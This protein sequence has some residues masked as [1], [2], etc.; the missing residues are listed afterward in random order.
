MTNAVQEDTAEQQKANVALVEKMYECFNRA[1]LDT[2][3]SE[4]FAADLVWILP[5]RNPVGGVKNGPDEVL[6]FFGALNSANIQVDLDRID[7]WGPDTVVE[8]H[9]GHGT[10]NGASLDALN[11]THYKIA[12]GR[13][14]HV[15]VYLSDQYAAD[16][17][18]WAAFGLVKIPDRLVA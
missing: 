8:V 13:I 10:S 12:D 1:D 17:F 9:R 2:I 15:Q 16:N 5:G 14:S 18:F 6:A 11:C 4:V 7:A 3:K